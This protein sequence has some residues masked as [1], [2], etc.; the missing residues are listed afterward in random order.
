MVMAAWCAVLIVASVAVAGLATLYAARAQ[1][2]NAADAG[3]LA[4]A[5]ATYPPAGDDSPTVAARR[6]V[7]LNGASLVVCH[8]ALDSGH[9]ART[10]LVTAEVLA[11][12]PVF[13]TV[14]VRGSSRAEFDPRL[15]LGVRGTG[16]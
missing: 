3:A 2:E 11:D 4:A 12:V 10:V 15:W 9:T 16:G 5:V 6:L 1:A 7:T 13:G 14:T 8:C